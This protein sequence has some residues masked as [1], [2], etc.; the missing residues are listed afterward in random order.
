MSNYRFVFDLCGDTMCLDVSQFW[1]GTGV[2]PA[3]LNNYAVIHKV[4]DITARNAI[5]DPT[6]I[7]EVADASADVNAPIGVPCTY[8]R[9]N[10][11]AWY[12]LTTPIPVY[13]A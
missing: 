9:I 12:I 1:D 8:Y 4:A 13:N 3:V 11:G 5:A 7:C 2:D 10:G 6:A